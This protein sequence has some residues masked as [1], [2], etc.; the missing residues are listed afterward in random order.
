MLI[1]LKT[2]LMPLRTN[3]LNRVQGKGAKFSSYCIEKYEN[4]SR[5]SWSSVI[6]SISI[7]STSKVTDKSKLNLK[8]LLD[9]YERNFALGQ[10]R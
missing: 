9:K 7:S 1:S 5:V 6:L 10:Q 8:L 4:K 2:L 3:I